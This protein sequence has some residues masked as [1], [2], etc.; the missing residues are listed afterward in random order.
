[1][2]YEKD[3]LCLD[4]FPAGTLACNCT[5]IYEKKSRE[6]L[7]VDP[8]NDLQLIL[9]YVSKNKLKVKSLLH[10]H[11]HFDHI[12]ASEKLAQAFSCPLYLHEKDFLLYEM[13]PFQ[14]QFF[15]MKADTPSSPPLKLNDEEFFGLE[16]TEG[17]RKLKEFLKTLYTPGHTEGSCSFYTE[18]FDKPV[19]LSGDTLFK[20]SV[21]RTDLPGGDHDTLVKSIKTRLLTLPEETLCIPGHGPETVIY[22]EK[23]ANPFL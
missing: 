5:V 12:G 16:L 23:R 11:A 1:M 2:F 10:T 15:G 13:L 20:G 14:A 22:S 21:G 9:D 4:S 6:A 19:L 8:G 17:T 3:S 7:I 18:F